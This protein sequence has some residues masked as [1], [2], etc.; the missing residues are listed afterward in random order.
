MNCSFK[1]VSLIDEWRV[2]PSSLRGTVAITRCAWVPF[3]PAAC[4]RPGFSAS[5]LSC[6]TIF[7]RHFFVVASWNFWPQS[8]WIPNFLSSLRLLGHTQLPSVADPAFSDT[9]EKRFYSHIWCQSFRF[10]WSKL[11]LTS[12]SF[13]FIFLRKNDAPALLAAT[14]RTDN[15]IFCPEYKDR[16]ILEERVQLTKRLIQIDVGRNHIA[17]TPLSGHRVFIS[18]D[19][20]NK[21]LCFAWGTSMII[22]DCHAQN[23][24]VSFAGDDTYCEGAYA[25]R[26]A[27]FCM[28]VNIQCQ[29]NFLWGGGG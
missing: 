16:W 15:D 19:T 24:S 6:R 22:S 4:L 17:S 10:K 13:G 29:F 9:R 18:T 7:L 28:S 8:M 21:P 12:L 14:K 20:Q 25:K 1:A 11:M 3:F 2:V 27:L 26:T 5:V 23:E